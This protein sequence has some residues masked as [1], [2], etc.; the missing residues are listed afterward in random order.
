MYVLLAVYFFGKTAGSIP[1]DSCSDI[2]LIQFSGDHSSAEKEVHEDLADVPSRIT[3][4]TQMWICLMTEVILDRLIVIENVNNISI[5]GQENSVIQCSN[6]SEAGFRFTNVQ[7]LNISGIIFKNCAALSTVDPNPKQNIRASISIQNSSDIH[8]SD[9][10]VLSSPGTGLALYDIDSTLDIVSSNFEGNGHDKKSGG[11]GLFI[12]VSEGSTIKSSRLVYSITNCSFINNSAETTI[13]N[14]RSGFT[15]FDKGGGICIYIR[16]HIG[17]TITIEHSTIENNSATGYGGGVFAAFSNDVRNSVITVRDSNYTGNSARYGGAH[18]SSYLHNRGR[19]QTP[20]NCS[21]SFSSSTFTDNRAEYGGGI[22]VF[23]TSVRTN[24]AENDVSFKNCTWKRNS[25]NFGSAI[26][27]LPNAWNLNTAD[28]YLPQIYFSK[29]II[30]SNN[31]V[32][33][34]D[35]SSPLVRQY[36]RGCG[37]LFTTDHTI[38]FN[39]FNTFVSNNGSA[40]YLSRSVVKFLQKSKTSFK[41]NTGFDGGAIHQVSS[42]IHFSENSTVLFEGN[43]AYSKGGAVFYT[44][45]DLHV[46]YY[47]RTCFFSYRKQVSDPAKRNITI[48]FINNLAETGYG[49]SIYA[50]SLRPCYRVFRFS[51]DNITSEIFQRIGNVTYFPVGREM[52]IATA[53]SHSEIIAGV[54]TKSTALPGKQVYLPFI[55]VDDLGQDSRTVYL[56]TVMEISENSSIKVDRA[57]NYISNDEILLYGNTGDTAAITLSSLQ[58]QQRSLIFNMTILPCPPGFKLSPLGN[59][60]NSGQCDCAFRT[61]S[62]YMGIEHC[63]MDEVRAYRKRGYWV[64]YTETESEMLGEDSLITGYCPLGFCSHS[65]TLLLPNS[66]D[67]IT[68]NEI[69]CDSRSGTLCAKCMRNHSVFYHSLYFTCKHEKYC[70]YGWVFYI[71]SELLPVTV[72]FIVI[73]MFNVSFTSGLINGFIFYSQVVVMFHVT[74]DDF[75]P[76]PSGVITLN[77]VLH[78]FYLFFNLNVF[79]LDEISFCLFGK[80]TA[81]DV[82]AFSYITL[83]YSFFLIIGIVLL[84]NKLN[85]RYC[86]RPLKKCIGPHWQHTLGGS[87]IHGLTAF[88]V[89]CYAKC[90]QASIL[91]LSPVVIRGKGKDTINTVVFYSGDITWLSMKHLP[92]AIPAFIMGTLLVILPPLLLLIYP[93]HYKVLSALRLS[94][95]VCVS[96]SLHRLNK[97][98]PLMDSFQGSFKDEYRFFSGLY[99]MY[100]FFLLVNVTLNSFQEVYVVILALLLFMTLFHAVCQPYKQRLHNI[101]DSLLFANLMAINGIT[102]YNFSTI[103]SGSKEEPITETLGYVQSFLIGLP[104]FVFILCLLRKVL[105]C[106]GVTSSCKKVTEQENQEFDV[107][108]FRTVERDMDVFS[109]NY[110]RV[111]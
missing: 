101:I 48:K 59:S 58:S 4:N 81:L 31:V 22:S 43:T 61:E 86:Y 40:F 57:Y 53:A 105:L 77:R 39:N 37:A 54:E 67:R 104:F 8:I 29:C 14:S 1:D 82:A 95:S 71:L 91:L 85:L 83:M 2:I 64:G 75:I 106:T 32:D 74:A 96:F 49:H 78:L 110:Q 79:T 109:M 72:I 46:Y 3:S 62:Q 76:M 89:L 92:Y 36:T 103:Q 27:I 20:L 6:G 94:E 56:V 50:H 19:N 34:F 99:F 42:V 88:L 41:L 15:R 60:Q 5:L 45:H 21:H 35:N 24:S 73:L 93:L 70:E 87:I 28:G 108:A 100:R 68:L 11:N 44:S 13:D 65:D 10:G 97:L 84:M 33:T 80:A 23:S 98:K 66:S 26:A 9:I 12:E 63:N 30:E 52:E 111:E 90:A 47:S 107:L 16:S 17:I 69:V 7:K 25:G 102:I 18:Y 38:K 55:D 51:I